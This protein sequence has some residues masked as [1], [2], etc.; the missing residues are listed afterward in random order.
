MTVQV[1]IERFPGSGLGSPQK[2]SNDVVLSSEKTERN[3]GAI[4]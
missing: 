1:Q 3:R 4:L 2:E